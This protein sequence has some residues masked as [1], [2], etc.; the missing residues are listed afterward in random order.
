[1]RHVRT[2]IGFLLAAFIIGM[3]IFLYAPA[4]L[5]GIQT[6]STPAAG[7]TDV[8]FRPLASGVQSTITTRTNFVIRSDSELRE[9]WKLLDTS[10][11]PPTIDFTRN[12]VVAVFAGEKETADHAIAV[13]RVV[14]FA[15]E[16]LVTITLTKPGGTCVLPP[17]ATAP[18]QVLEL[19]K[20]TL[21]L[22]HIDTVTATSCL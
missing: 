3:A 2:V 14:D 11:L 7:Q 21:P 10:D 16:R 8:H 1:M 13:T 12:I 6:A 19:S 18:Y 20:T 5:S 9:L 22:T 15:S 17:Q 4:R